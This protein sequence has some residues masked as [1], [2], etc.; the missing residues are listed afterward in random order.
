MCGFAQTSSPLS[1]SV[2]Q[3]IRDTSIV[4]CEAGEATPQP[5]ILLVDD[6]SALRTLVHRF[7]DEEGYQVL[8]AANGI[9]AL[10]ICSQ[11][12]H[13][14][15]LLVTDID[16]PGM[17]GFELA[18]HVHKLRPEMRVLVMTG[19]AASV[20]QGWCSALTVVP[21]PF[22]TSVLISTIRQELRS[23]EP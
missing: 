14:I 11:F 15:A 13:P 19:G 16:M 2:I 22:D 23:F 5:T 9:E 20:P 10:A 12:W 1:V 8:I 17:T 6:D 18:Q 7:L 4:R 21:K 3:V